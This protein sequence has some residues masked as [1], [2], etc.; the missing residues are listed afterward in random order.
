MDI[1]IIKAFAKERR[2]LHETN[3]EECEEVMEDYWERLASY[4]ASDIA[5]AIEFMTN[6]PECTGEVFSDW[7]EVFEDVV[8]KTQS[9]TFLEALAVAEKRFEKDSRECNI[10][11]MIELAG[12]EML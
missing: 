10:P 7:S 1:D 2:E 4:I 11:A 9:R 6:S 12:L 3:R 8:R 5:G